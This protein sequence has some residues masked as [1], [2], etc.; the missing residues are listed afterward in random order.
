MIAELRDGTPVGG[1]L[2]KANPDVWDVLTFLRS[3]TEVDS[4]RMAR[5]YRVDLLRPG[6]PAVLWVTGAADARHTAGVWAI[7][8]IAGEVYEDV[9]DPADPLWRDRSAQRQ[10]RPHVELAMT[11]LPTPVPRSEVR[12][13]PRFAGAEII[14]RPRMGSPVALRPGELDVI[15]ELAERTSQSP[16]GLR[17]RRGTARS[18]R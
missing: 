8:E 3:G 16:A 18:R 14:R 9:G 2:F 15:R 5:S 10:V 4:W 11:V 1:W 12:D 7:G 17:A 13:D 6:Q